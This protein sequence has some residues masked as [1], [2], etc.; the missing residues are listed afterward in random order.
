MTLRILGSPEDRILQLVNKRVLGLFMCPLPPPWL[1][2]GNRPLRLGWVGKQWS[3]E[4]PHPDSDLLRC[5]ARAHGKGPTHSL[6]L[7]PLAAPRPS[8]ALTQAR[9]MPL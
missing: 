8:F 3:P 5:S 1:T 4:V 2:P 9:V 7:E 6:A